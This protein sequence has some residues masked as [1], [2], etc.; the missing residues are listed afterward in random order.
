MLVSHGHFDHIADAVE[1]AKATHPT[2]A[3]MVEL[4]GMLSSIAGN[5]MLFPWSP[6]SGFP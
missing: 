1:I 4:A 6:P 2:V 5:C 3:A